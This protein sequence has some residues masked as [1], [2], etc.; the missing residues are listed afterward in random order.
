MS[1]NSPAITGIPTA[2]SGCWEHSGSATWCWMSPGMEILLRRRRRKK[3]K[4]QTFHWLPN[5][6]LHTGSSKGNVSYLA[7]VVYT[8]IQRAQG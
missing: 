1:S 8:E 7:I 4:K 6:L 2:R 3:K 5:S